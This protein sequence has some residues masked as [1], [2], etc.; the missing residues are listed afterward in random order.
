MCG[1][2]G[3]YHFQNSTTTNEKTV[4]KMRDTLIHRG[5][6]SAGFYISK[7]EK[8][9]LG[10]RRLA[11]IDLSPAGHQPLS[12]EDKTVWIT[13]NGEIYN[14]QELKTKLIKQGHRFRSQTDTETIVHLWEEYGADCLKYLRGM[15]AFALWDDKKKILF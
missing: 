1:I 6:D 8:V 12:N 3:V 2:A 14:F 10:H 13:F 5:P 7:D 9:G 11:I 15:F 4:V